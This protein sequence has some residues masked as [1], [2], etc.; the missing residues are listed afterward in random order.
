VSDQKRD[1]DRLIEDGLIRYGG[2]DLAGA[3]AAWE[4]ALIQEPGNLQAIGYIDYVR[5]VFEQLNRPTRDELVVPFGLG[6]GDAPDYQIEISPESP[7]DEG[8]D[9]VRRSSGLQDGWPIGAD[10]ERETALR[11]TSLAEPPGTLDLELELDDPMG[12]ETLT[13]KLLEDSADF[14]D[15]T[16][17]EDLQFPALAAPQAAPLA[18]SSTSDASNAVPRAVPSGRRDDDRDGVGFDGPEQELTPGFLETAAAGFSEPELTPGFADPSSN[19][20]D[21]RRPELGF[22]RARQPTPNTLR[23]PGQLRSDEV[24]PPVPPPPGRGK[25]PTDS[26]PVT[27]TSPTTPMMVVRP[28]RPELMRPPEA[29]DARNAQESRDVRETHDMHDLRATRDL[30]DEGPGRNLSSTDA[31]TLQRPSRSNLGGAGLGG[32]SRPSKPGIPVPTE[33]QSRPALAASIEP[34]RSSSQLPSAAPIVGAASSSIASGI[35]ISP[36]EHDSS[37]TSAAEREPTRP[38]QS[39]SALL[40]ANLGAAQPAPLPTPRPA[41]GLLDPWVELA[42][43]NSP[44]GEEDANLEMAPFIEELPSSTDGAEPDT[45]PPMAPRP[46]AMTRNLGLAGRYRPR[47]DLKFGEESPTRELQRP[48]TEDEEKTQAWATPPGTAVP[49]DALEALGSQILPK[50]ERDAPPNESRDDRLRRRISTLVELANEWIRLGDPRRAV[51]A[52][53]L[54]LA[55]DPDSALAQKLVHRNRDAI[56]TI[57]QGYLGSLERRPS[58]ARSLDALG[59]SPIGARAAFLLSRVDG[60]LTYDEILDV[61]GMPRLEAYRYLC[62][63]LIRG[64]LIVE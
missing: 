36:I 46:E 14:G 53:D 31:P 29:R 45:Q 32:G 40:G 15:V 17:V 55:E 3:L 57:F 56:M 22:V 35:P 26:P 9:A 62:Q 1:V 33:R 48:G 37:G 44:A 23:R 60:H 43:G 30:R 11:L 39:V 61:S 28:G 21:L 64:I 7:D 10:D 54:A 4:R 13:G 52:V 18:G 42:E 8:D 24:E 34:R 27:S 6:H 25:E 47:D 19:S 49:A 59:A 16:P 2:G 38:R 51:A 20:T 58:L 63:L 5:Q 12:A 50:L 41:P